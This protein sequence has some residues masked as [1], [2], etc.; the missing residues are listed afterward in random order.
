MGTINMGRVI[1]GGLLAGL[2]FNLGETVFN[3]FLFGEQMEA[4]MQRLGLE[5]PGGGAIAVYIVMGF[6]GGIATVWLYA[7]IRPR[8]GPGPKT[9]V[10]AGLAVWLLAYLFPTVGYATQGIIPN[11]LA[12]IGAVWGLAELLIAAQAG[13]WLY[14]EETA[15]A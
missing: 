11:N 9:A 6:V 14:R 4:A 5:M 15:T 10:F 13:C 8:F 12:A 1:L 7:A 3:L 2:V